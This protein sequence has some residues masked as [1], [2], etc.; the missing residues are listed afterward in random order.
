MF[1]VIKPINILRP[2]K[3]VDGQS[4]IFKRPIIYSSIPETTPV[5]KFTLVEEMTVYET[6]IWIWTLGYNNRWPEAEWYAINFQKNAVAGYMLPSLSLDILKHYLGVQNPNHRM[7]IRS[8]INFLFSNTTKAEQYKAPTEIG[9]GDAR[10]GSVD[11]SDELESLSSLTCST[12]GSVEDMSES[13]CTP[14]DNYM[15]NMLVAENSVSKNRCLILSL[16][17]YQQFSLR[18]TEQLRSRFAEFNYTV[19]IL[20]NSSKPNSY[21]IIFD[22]EQNALKAFARSK[23]IGYNLAK[24]GDGHPSP[25]N[26]VRF[27][28][29][30]T[31][32]VRVGISFND[33]KIGL[34]KKNQI[35]TVNQVEGRR[36]HI[37]FAQ[38]KER[39]SGWVSLHNGAGTTFLEQV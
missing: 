8:A 11:S 3:V 23:A 9:L 31:L 1:S 35:V 15:N 28:A 30:I 20:P 26:H 14:R 12:S 2:V 19:K 37:S 16:N 39:L 29:L 38:D 27:K 13:N 34:L 21:I 36:A 5:Q 32:K 17:P 22:N 6:S 18:E 10:Q 7:A 33:R 4:G 25:F 24:Y